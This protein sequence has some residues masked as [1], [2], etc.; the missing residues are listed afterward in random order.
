MKNKLNKHLLRC[1]SAMRVIGFTA[2]LTFFVHG[3]AFSV[4]AQNRNENTV[5]QLSV[6]KTPL[7]KVFEKI[8]EQSK[9]R[10]LYN[11][12][13]LKATSPISIKINS[14][15]IR[16]IVRTCIEGQ[17]LEF[18]I[19]V[20]NVIVIRK[21]KPTQSVSQESKNH[22][23]KG[24]VIDKLTGESL[25]G[26]SVV[27]KEDGKNINGV[28][29]DVNGAF[30]LI[31]HK[32]VKNLEV[33]FIGYVTKTVPVTDK[34]LITIYLEEDVQTMNDVVITGYFA[35][36]KSSFTG[37]ITQITKQE[38][39]KFGKTNIISILSQ[40][41]PSFKIKE[42][43]EI[44]SDPNRLPQFFIRG[45]GSFFGSGNVPTFIVDGYEVSLRYIFDMDIDRIE[46][47]SI[48]KDASATI[49][50]GSRA[51][52]GVV[53]IET[54]RPEPGEL[55]V[56]YTNRSSLSVPDLTDYNLM[57]AKEK[58]EF[59][60]LAGV[61]TSEDPKEQH[62]LN[63]VY[64]D[65][66][67]DIARGVDTY[68]LSQPLRNAFSHGHSIYV[69]G[70]D[71]KVTYG[72]GANYD[73]KAGVMKK[74][75]RNNYGIN[76][77]LTYRIKDKFSVRNS[78]S[79]SHTS[80]QNSPYGKFHKYATANPYSPT[81]LK[82]F[83]QHGTYRHYNY[84]H[85]AKLAH[86]DVKNIGTIV[87][88]LSIDYQ[89]AK[90]FR[91]KS[92]V[93][94]RKETMDAEQYTSPLSGIYVGKD[95]KNKGYYGV[96]NSKS[97]SYDIS[98]TLTHNLEFNKHIL[99]YG[100]G[101]N[102]QDSERKGND[103]AATGFLDERFNDIKFA[104][105]FA[106]GTKPNSTDEVNRLVGF[107]GNLNYSY[108]N[109]YFADFSMRS[110]GSSK[111]GADSKFGSF[112][113]VGAGWNIHREK[114]M[115]NVK[116]VEDLK[117]RGSIGLT[118]NQNF[119][120]TMA[121]TIYNYYTDDIYYQ[122]LGAHF[123]QYGN[124]NLKW[125]KGFKRNIGL[126]FKLLDRRLSLSFDYYSNKTQGLLLPVT[127][128]PS[129]GFSSYTE[130]YGEQQNYGYEFNVS[131]VVLRNADF[132]WALYLS[133]SHNKNKIV[134]ISNVL[135]KLNKD[136]N[137]DETLF[138]EPIAFYEEGESLSSIK[139]VRSMGID[140]ETGKELYLT[141]DGKVTDVWNYKDKV[142]LGDT[143]PTLSGN[144]G[145]NFMWRQFSLAMNFRYSFGAQ[146]YNRTLAFRVEG[147]DPHINAD[148]RV[149]EERWKK[150]GDHTFYKNIADRTVPN[151]SSRFVQDNDYLEL[152]NVSLSYQL[153]RELVKKWG[154]TDVRFRFNM[155]ELF[156]LS[157]VKRER[158]LDYPF[159]RQFTFTLNLKF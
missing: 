123:S 101:I 132:D 86:R 146:I 116:W 76:F 140:P 111:Y 14:K 71:Q 6:K 74:S 114:F 112:W 2:M 136:K 70:G 89:F 134:K 150:P 152:S 5:I 11:T 90:N 38:I 45:E 98:S 13:L 34:S 104:L 135:A 141:K 122:S 27:A 99:Y 118:G 58:L 142:K 115:S 127:V 87:N 63:K 20:D 64:N 54:R 107:L 33:S 83:N 82:T 130:N 12:E 117:L 126:D 52:N 56:R 37:A 88:N 81:D 138:T 10:F 26:A 113:S 39:Q 40:V 139:A 93:S 147:V 36:P 32:S 148:K 68:W 156:Y 157:T 31:V 108:D 149:L 61:Y 47:L 84:L 24:K 79:Y 62:R 97:F 95:V 75:K 50:Y 131:G 154:L 8:E 158:G 7:S 119:D 43:D 1:R 3:F 18:D 155:N 120:P 69:S 144:F 16:K 125:Q 42:N 66:A 51:A 35:K 129:L 15:D 103:Y 65:I 44:G 73:N 59:E 55:Q 121:K 133:G 23:L 72:L 53:V 94:L 67:T 60:R 96:K 80:S 102:I 46:S 29:T 100:L 85:D 145:T 105:Q 57:N 77:D 9:W 22:V 91:L 4:Q 92:S 78:L 151:V 25:I 48:L 109:R 110:D 124:R 21:K 153:N 137:S 143:A 17:G 106:E 159:S 28:A 30:E 41:D 49:H 19:Q 128:A